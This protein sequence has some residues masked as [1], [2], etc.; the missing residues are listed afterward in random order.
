MPIIA[1]RTAARSGLAPSSP[2]VAG[3]DP[4]WWYYLSGST[5]PAVVAAI[6]APRLAARPGA[7]APS[8]S[9]LPIVAPRLVARV[10]T[11]APGPYSLRD[12]VALWLR[13]NLPGLGEVSTG[14]LVR[15]RFPAVRVAIVS[16]SGSAASDA[17][18]VET[19]V[20]QVS[21]FDPSGA[22][23]QAKADEAKSALRDAPLRFRYGTLLYLTPSSRLDLAPGRDTG[24]GATP[25]VHHEARSFDYVVQ[26]H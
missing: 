4:G 9:S 10:A 6:V 26:P 18:E 3:Y 12:A 13:D 20:V 25:S 5:P 2:P 17:S 8:A 11:A 23:A 22:A 1:P 16:G 21:V 7:R 19:G 15:G 24:P 14:L